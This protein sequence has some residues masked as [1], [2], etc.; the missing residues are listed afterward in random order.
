MYTRL[1]SSILFPLHE[2]LKGHR[3]VGLRKELERSQW[4]TGD[5]LAN[6]QATALREFFTR[7]D[8]NVPYYRDLF[9]RI[10]VKPEQFKTIADLQALPFLD[11]PT[12]RG[13]VDELKSN[14]AKKLLRY[15]TGG[16][17]GEPLVFY[18]GM[19][20]VAHDVAAKWRADAVVG[21]GHWRR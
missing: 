20:R 21:R 10:G 1:C 19:D 16:S 8:R 7:V 6:A 18:M 2:K 11:K 4:L 3:T 15:N 12:I 14:A 5:D 17:S 9:A 13:H